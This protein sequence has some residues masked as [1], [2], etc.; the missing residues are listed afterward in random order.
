[1]DLNI[2]PWLDA[3]WQRFLAVMARDRVPHALLLAGPGGV[4]MEEFAACMAARLLCERPPAEGVTCGT[5]RSCHLLAAGSHPDFMR[6]EGDPKS[7]QIRID[8]VREMIHFLQLSTHYGRKVA[9]VLPADAMNR[10][11]ANSLLKILEEP[12]PDSVLILCTQRPGT[13]PVTIRSRCQRIL[14]HAAREPGIAQWLAGRAG[15]DASAAAALLERHGG[16]P[17][18]A[19]AAAGDFDADRSAEL[20][21]DLAELRART[22]NPVRVAQKWSGYGAAGVLEEVAAVLAQA[23]RLKLEGGRAPQDGHLQRMADELDLAELVACYDAAMRAWRN[24]AGPFNLNSQSVIEA[25]IARWQDPT[26][27][28]GG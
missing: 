17:L 25:F 20:A 9:L 5:C 8:M 23:A 1:M 7:G 16:A 11:A 18:R 28:S 21:A 6:L 12:P 19:L 4:G 22:G 3:Q 26:I 24:A 15:L 10:A 27:N 14:F 2:Y 13:L